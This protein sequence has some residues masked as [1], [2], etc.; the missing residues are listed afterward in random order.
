[1]AGEIAIEKALKLT[2]KSNSSIKSIQT[3]GIEKTMTKG[4]SRPEW[5]AK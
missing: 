3:K 2:T 1:M 5:A 4:E